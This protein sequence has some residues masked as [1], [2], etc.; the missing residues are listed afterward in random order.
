MFKNEV[1]L[2]TNVLSDA[3]RMALSMGAVAAIGAV[4][5]A[6][7]QDQAASPSQ[8]NQQ[9]QSLETIVVTGSHIRR[10]DIETSNPVV[11]LSTQQIQSSGKLTLGDVIQA[12]PVMTGSVTNGR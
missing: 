8:I 1:K 9:S 12:L 7:A 4:G 3:V 6:Y 11:T 2:G 10:V 5:S